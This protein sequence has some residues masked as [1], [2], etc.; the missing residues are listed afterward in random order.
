MRVFFLSGSQLEDLEATL[1]L[2]PA[3]SV[4]KICKDF[5]LATK[6]NHKHDFIETLISHSKKK[7]FFGPKTSMHQLIMKK[8]VL[9]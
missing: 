1:K 9:M 5:N 2:L 3:A 4:R 8:Y 7:S 6:G